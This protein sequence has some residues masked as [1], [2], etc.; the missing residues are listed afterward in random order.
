MLSV[1]ILT[2]R[3]H[4]FLEA[5]RRRPGVASQSGLAYNRSMGHFYALCKV[6]GLQWFADLS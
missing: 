5:E 4:V 3:D 2:T 6:F 1:F